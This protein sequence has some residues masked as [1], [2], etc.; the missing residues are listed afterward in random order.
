M[1]IP[2]RF[3]YE[4]PLVFRSNLLNYFDYDPYTNDIDYY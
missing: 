2:G 3:Y 4:D 1:S